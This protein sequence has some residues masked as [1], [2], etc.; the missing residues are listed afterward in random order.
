VGCRRGPIAAINSFTRDSVPKPL[1]F[2]DFTSEWL[3][4]GA[5]GAARYSGRL[6]GAVQQLHVLGPVRWPV[7]ANEQNEL[8]L[9]EQGR[10][11]LVAGIGFA[12][13]AGSAIEAY[14]R[15]QDGGSRLPNTH[16]SVTVR[17]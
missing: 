2:I 5:A 16:C 9:F 6:V 12:R 14:F 4:S 3:A 17:D 7:L 15:Q 11:S 8:L 13:T 1:G 10:L